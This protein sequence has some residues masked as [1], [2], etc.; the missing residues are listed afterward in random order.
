MWS[1]GTVYSPRRGRSY[2]AEITLAKDGRLDVKVK[3]GILSK[4]LYW[5]R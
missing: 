3:D 1:G 2:P 5:T 4:H